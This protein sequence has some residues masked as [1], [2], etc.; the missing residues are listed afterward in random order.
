MVWS[1]PFIKS[2]SCSL[3]V[4]PGGTF[5]LNKGCI[6]YI[7]SAWMGHYLI[8]YCLDFIYRS[9][10]KNWNE[11]TQVL[12][13]FLYTHFIRLT[14]DLLLRQ[15]V[16]YHWNYQS[17]GVRSNFRYS[18]DM[19]LGSKV[20]AL[21]WVWRCDNRIYGVSL[22]FL[23]LCPDTRIPHIVTV[24]ILL[25]VCLLFYL[26]TAFFSWISFKRLSSSASWMSSRFP[27]IL[28]S[29]FSPYLSP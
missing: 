20:L 6:P 17:K 2:E 13:N 29:A 14:H 18:N 27:Q 8:N 11:I 26:S 24:L 25:L 23:R 28:F 19:N 1:Q 21:K 9:L 15:W 16:T 22:P 5:A 12:L 4:F 7:S 3:E 10:N